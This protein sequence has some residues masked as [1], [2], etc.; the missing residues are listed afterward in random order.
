MAAMNRPPAFI[1]ILASLLFA[2]ASFLPG[3]KALARVFL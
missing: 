3:A 2:F 1:L